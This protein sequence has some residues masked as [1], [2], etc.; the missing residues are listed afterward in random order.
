[1]RRFSIRCAVA[2]VVIACMAASVP[3][4]DV[5]R[6]LRS[7]VFPGMGQ[8]GDDQMG[9]G[10]LYMAG[11]IAL[12]SLTVDQIVKKAAAD[13]STEYFQVKVANEPN[14]ERKKDLES[15]WDQA[16]DDSEKSQMLTY[17]FGGTALLWW[18][19]NIVDAIAFAPRDNEEAL[20]RKIKDNTVVAVGLDRAQLAYKIDF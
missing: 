15:Q 17:V 9:R 14:Y 1:M 3:A 12:L 11:E 18:A 16:I 7:S 10:L 20:I 5:G 19:W 6:A 13:R 4:A 2:G 8:L